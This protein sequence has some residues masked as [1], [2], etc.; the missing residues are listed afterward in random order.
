MTFGKRLNTSCRALG[1]SHLARDVSRTC[2]A[3]QSGELLEENGS[4][5]KPHTPGSFDGASGKVVGWV[6]VVGCFYVLRAKI[7]M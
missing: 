5:P 6:A 7:Y 1:A 3:V 2:F 4:K